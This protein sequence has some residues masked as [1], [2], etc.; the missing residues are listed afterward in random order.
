MA[1]QHTQTSRRGAADTFERFCRTFVTHRPFRFIA[2]NFLGFVLINGFTF[3]VDLVLLTILHGW[4]EL[5]V[6]AAI[7][8]SYLSAF[9]LSFALNRTLNFRSHSP[10]GRQLAWYLGAITVNYFVFLLGVGGGLAAFGLEYHLSRIIAGAGEGVFMYSA[11]R[12]VVF[13]R[14]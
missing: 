5:P 10:A 11:M 7:T 8:L 2:P 1:E 13:R 14:P 4:W 6:W 3:A 9:G 12:W